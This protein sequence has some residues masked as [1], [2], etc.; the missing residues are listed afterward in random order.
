M[1]ACVRACVSASV[2]A[3]V[4]ACMCTQVLACLRARY[5]TSCVRAYAHTQRSASKIEVNIKSTIIVGKLYNATHFVV[6]GHTCLCACPQFFLKNLTIFQAMNNF[7]L[8]I[9]LS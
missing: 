7:L 6:E 9:R 1:R 8:N 5:R 4:H 3:C 2:R